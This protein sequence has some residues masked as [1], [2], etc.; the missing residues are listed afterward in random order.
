ML[1]RN[2]V[3][4]E[5]IYVPAFLYAVCSIAI[6]DFFAL[7][8][9]LISLTLV[10]VSMDYLIQRMDNVAKDELFLYP[11]FYLGMAGMFYLPSVVF[12]VV[13][14]LAMVVIVQAK[15]RRILLY[16]FGWLTANGIVLTIIY[17]T[18]I[19]AD[20]WTSA[21]VELFRE[22]IY[23]VTLRDMGIWMLFPGLLFLLAL[24]ASLGSR[25]G[26]LH[27][28]TQQFMVLILL[29]SVGVIAMGGT[30]SGI[31]LIFFVPVF[32]FFLT[33]YFIKIR[34]KFWRK[35][36]PGLMILGSLT[37]PLVAVYFELPDDKLIIG[38]NESDVSNQRVMV[39]GPL[40]PILRNNE[41]A[42]PFFDERISR[43]RV[44]DL[45]YY[46][47]SLIWRDIFIKSNPDLVMDEWGLLE[48]VEYRFPEVEEMQIPRISN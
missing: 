8:P 19:W 10:I 29:A 26:S 40:D 32:S 3:L 27:V 12:F 11:G 20:F 13:F 48:K 5:P 37:A 1:L 45:D 47:R 44:E 7:S 22:K 42:G 15:P 25:E 9:Q 33:N 41:M 2:K 35:M 24:F 39:L 31:D 34:R 46:Q 30:L 18:G 23:Y 6:F 28:K 43:E 17:L 38:Y 14:L 16:I 4:S 36:L 21:L